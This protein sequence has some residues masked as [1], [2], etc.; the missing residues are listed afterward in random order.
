MRLNA[1]RTLCHPFCFST[2]QF[3][4]ISSTTQP[5]YGATMMRVISYADP[6]TLTAPA[7]RAQNSKMYR[8]S[9][10]G[11]I[12]LHSPSTMFIWSFIDLK[13]K[14]RLVRSRL[15]NPPWMA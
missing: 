10:P 1:L 2:C 15:G 8:K 13:T 11:S 7:V 9:K 3:L 6:V 14:A 4:D 5:P 12:I